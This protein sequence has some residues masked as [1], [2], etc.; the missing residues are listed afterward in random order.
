M[1]PVWNGTRCLFCDGHKEWLH[2]QCTCLSRSAFLSLKEDKTTPFLC[3]CCRLDRQE[4]LIEDLKK[5]LDDKNTHLNEITAGS[6]QAINTASSTA[7]TVED[8]PH[9]N[10]PTRGLSN[11]NLSVNNHV[12]PGHHTLK[13]PPIEGRIWSSLVFVSLLLVP[14]SMKGWSMITI[15][16]L[17]L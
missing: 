14:H 7:R 3:P 15:L 8:L 12:S 17:P 11:S 2:R 5:Q 9:D 10:R 4:A 16:Y 1:S 6:N 13:T